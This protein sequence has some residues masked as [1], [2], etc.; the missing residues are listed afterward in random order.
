VTLFFHCGHAVFAGHGQNV[1]QRQ[2][3]GFLEVLKETFKNFT[4]LSRN[5]RNLGLTGQGALTSV[6]R[7]KTGGYAGL[8]ERLR[9]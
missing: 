6:R 4:H 9:K 5:N 8:A 2:G 1:A 7:V 3:N